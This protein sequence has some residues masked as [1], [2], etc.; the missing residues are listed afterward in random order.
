M[1][2]VKECSCNKKYYFINKGYEKIA[3]PD[4]G[5]RIDFSDT[6]LDFNNN[7]LTFECTSPT[8]NNTIKIDLS[9]EEK[10][11][12]ILYTTIIVVSEQIKITDILNDIKKEYYCKGN[13]VLKKYLNELKSFNILSIENKN[14]TIAITKDIYLDSI[15]LILNS[16]EAE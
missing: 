6:I 1:E 10:A 8:C 2:L 3:K 15:N 5:N 11:L 9:E 12:Y 14:L 4:N 7:V 16:M 13:E